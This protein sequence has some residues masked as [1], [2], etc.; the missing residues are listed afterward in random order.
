MNS[1]HK[2]LPHNEFGEVNVSAYDAMRVAL[3]SGNP[4]D[5]DAITLG[6][7]PNVK[8]TD[9]QSAFDFDL[10]GGDSFSYVMIPEPCFSSAQ[11]AGEITELY[12]MALMRDVNFDEYS[13]N[14]LAVDACKNLNAMSDFRGLKISDKVTPA[15]LFR[16][17]LSG[18]DRGPFL[19]QFLYQPFQYGAM[20]IIQKYHQ[21][22]RGTDYMTK[23][24]DWLKIQNGQKVAQPSVS[25]YL[26]Q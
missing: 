21:T 1:F 9:P 24:P 11:Q 17:T 23:F 18:C 2:G 12:S 13:I 8:L 15:T 26:I 14:P 19:S 10:Q 7:I 6:C 20:P 25:L 16:G 22:T 5:F 3:N 4:S